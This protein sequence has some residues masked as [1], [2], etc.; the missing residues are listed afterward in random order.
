MIHMGDEFSRMEC[1]EGSLP[2]ELESN[3]IAVSIENICF[4]E[5]HLSKISE[6]N[7][8]SIQQLRG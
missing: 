2:P 4:I 8:L 1:P 6:L 3:R 5:E 7:K